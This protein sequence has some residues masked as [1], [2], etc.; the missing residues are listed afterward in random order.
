M[1]MPIAIDTGS[2]ALVCFSQLRWNFV[3]QRPRH[4]LSPF[5]AKGRDFYIEEPVFASAPSSLVHTRGNLGVDVVVPHVAHG[6]DV[7][8]VL[9]NLLNEF[10]VQQQIQNY[11]LWFYTPHASAVDSPF[12]TTGG[13]V[14]LH[15]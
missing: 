15:G 12:E 2:T 13:G 5:A 14:R 10:F 11:A 6:D 9:K 8:E 7:T 3:Y 4:L 1:T